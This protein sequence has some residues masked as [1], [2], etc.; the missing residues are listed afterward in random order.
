LGFPFG[1]L[2]TG[3]FNLTVF[4]FDLKIGEHPEEEDGVRRL[5][6]ALD[7]ISGVGFLL[8][9]FDDEANFNQYMSWLQADATRC[10]FAPFLEAN[11]DDALFEHD[12]AYND[13]GQVMNTK[14]EGIFLSMKEKDRWAPSK[15]TIAYD[16]Q[17]G[18]AGLYFLIYQ[19]CPPPR[20]D[21]HSKVRQQRQED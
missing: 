8:K 18:D 1:F 13:F 5:P 7:D 9:R 10:A 20:E 4:D 21:I 19:V 14:E 15:P 11:E 2:D 3:C 16:F 17:K 12:D 6:S